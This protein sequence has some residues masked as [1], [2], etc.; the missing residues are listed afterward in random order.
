MRMS[1]Q[2]SRGDVLD[3]VISPDGSVSS[4]TSPATAER[5][6][7]RVRQVATG[8]DV[9]VLAATEGL[10]SPSFSP[11]GNYLFYLAVKPDAR[12]TGRC[13]KSPRWGLAH[14]AHVRR[15]FARQLLTGWQ[16]DRLLARRS[17]EARVSDR[18]LRPGRRSGARRSPR[19]R[20]PRSHRVRPTGL[21]DGKK[22]A[23]ILFQP[24]SNLRSTIALF[25]PGSGR[26]QRPPRDSS[27]SP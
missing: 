26:R 9:Q 24:R 22:L 17:A 16:T 13:S 14:R 11:D 18:H 27:G 19:W 12:P 4:P 2:T 8:S 23:A 6:S 10:Q 7:L 20:S 25:D 3:C 21:P 5:A 15:R 1:T